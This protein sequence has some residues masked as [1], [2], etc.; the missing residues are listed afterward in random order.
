MS[1]AAQASASGAAEDELETWLCHRYYQSVYYTQLQASVLVVLNPFRAPVDVN[2]DE[3]LRQYKRALWDA[4]YTAH[5]GALPPH[6]FGTACDAYFYM[7]RTGQDQSLLF[8]GESGAGKSETRRLAVRALIG[9]SAALPGKRGARLVTQLPAAL[10]VLECFGCAATDANANASATALYAELQFSHNGRL[11]G[12]K[13]LNYYLDRTRVQPGRTQERTFHVFY[14]LLA[15]AP[16]DARQRWQLDGGFSLTSAHGRTEAAPDPAR[17]WAYERLVAALDAAGVGAA[18]RGALFDVL[19]AM[20]HVSNLTFVQDNGAFAAARVANEE[21]LYIA[22]SLLGVGASALAN[23]LTHRTA[24]V[25]GDKYTAML[26][27]DDAAAARDAFLAMLYE[28][29]Y[30]WLCQHINEHFAAA[31]FDTYIG[32]LDAPSWTN[33]ARNGVP[34]FGANYMAEALHQHTLRVLLQRRTEELEHEG[35]AHLAPPLPALRDGAERMRLLTHYPGGLLHIMDEQTRRRPP[36]TDETMVAAMQKRWV[37]SRALRVA[38]PDRPGAQ[39]FTVSHFHGEV[40]YD[41]AGALAEN[42]VSFALEHISLLRGAAAGAPADGTSGFGS[43]RAFVRGLFA[44]MPV[45]TPFRDAMPPPA[46]A[47][48]MRRP[49]R[50]GT[51]RATSTRRRGDARDRDAYDGDGPARAPASNSAVFVGGLRTNL[52]ALLDVLGETK[53]W[54]VVCVRPNGNQLANQCEPRMV[55]RQVQALQLAELRDQRARNYSVSLTYAEFCERYGALRM[56]EGLR[57]GGAPRGEAKMRVGDAC[58]QM[59]WSDTHVALGAHKVFLSHAV[60]CELEDDLRADDPAEAQYNLRRAAADADGVPD[61]YAPDA[62]GAPGPG[63]AGAYAPLAD[64]AADPYAPPHTPRDAG[65]HPAAAFTYAG[66]HDAHETQSLLGAHGADAQAAE[67]N[68]TLMDD[69]RDGGPGESADARRP[70]VAERV[71]VSRLRRQWVVV[72]WLLTFWVPSFALMWRP[73][74]RRSDVRMAWREKLAINMLIWFVCACSIF[75]IVFLGNVV[76]PNEHLIGA[77]SLSGFASGDKVYTAIRGEVFDLAGITAGH[78]ATVPVVSRKTVMSYAG[79]DATGAFPVQVNALCNG[80][81]GAISPWVSLDNSNTTDPNAQYHDFRADTVYDVRPDWYYEQM[82]YMRS[83]HRVGFIGYTPGDISDAVQDGRTMAVVDGNLYDITDYVAQGSQGGVRVPSGMAAPADLDRTILAPA[84]V[85]LITASPGRDVSAQ[86]DALALGAEVL[87]WQKACLRNLYFV[88]RVDHRDTARCTFS[89]YILLALSLVMVATIAFKFF[90]AL[91]FG[92][93]RPTEDYDKFVL[94]QVPCYTEGTDSIKKTVDSLARLKYDDR[95]KLLVV[96]CDGNVVGAGNDA[97]TPQLVLELLG[98][99]T[100]ADV[101]PRSFVS[102][103]EGAKQHNMARV[104]SGLYEHAGHMVPYLVVAKCGTSD[105]HTRP[106]N[107]GKRDTQ[108]ILMRFLNK[109]HFGLPMSPLELE[110]YHHIKNII[111]VNPSFYE[112][113][114]QVDADTEVDPHAL[115]RMVAAFVRDQKV[116]GLCGETALANEQQSITTMLQV[117]EYYISHYLVKAFESL[118][119]SITCLPG[120]FSMFRLRASDT[121]RPLFISNAVLDDYAENRVDTL[122]TKNLLYLG[123]DRYLTTLVLKHFPAHKTVFVRDAKCL[124]IA[125]DSWRV[126]LSQRRRWI[127]STVHNLVE[128]L[129]TQQLCGFCCFSMRFVVLIDLLSTIVAPVTIGYLVYLVVIVAVDGG[130]I[131]VTSIILLAAIYGLQAII[132]LLHRR[133][134][135]IGWMVVYILGLPLWSLI[136]PLYSFWHM[137]DFSWGNTRIVTGDRGEKLVLHNEGTFQPADIPHM[138]WDDYEN[139][140]WEQRAAAPPASLSERAPS[141]YGYATHPLPAYSDAD[142]VRK[143]APPDAVDAPWFATEPLYKGMGMPPYCDDPSRASMHHPLQPTYSRPDSLYKEPI[144]E[145]TPSPPASLQRD[146]L[147]PSEAAPP[148]VDL[149]RRLPHDEVIRRDIRELIAASDLSTVTKRQ[150]RLQLQDL[151]GCAIDEKKAYI[152]AQIDAALGEM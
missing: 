133:F 135:M 2:S 22:A 92:R 85:N 114:F 121:Q 86:L 113:L 77:Q 71:H 63:A 14:L 49:A 65:P 64:A 117:Y 152:N 16:P 102:L 15:G 51:L 1:D 27:A 33:R 112:Y 10:H 26:D 118:F 52:D 109:T 143:D 120:C 90:A 31:H 88:G 11:L 45:W 43:S 124:T 13:A 18:E 68:A 24:A 41:A 17:L 21:P 132:F 108:L 97:P 4:R 138:S 60:F 151:Y 111:G 148:L 61:L 3:V 12:M 46:H 7:Q 144:H 93:S 9:L 149:R 62:D 36:K 23:A 8:L 78:V 39:P 20:L 103:G 42:D 119:G 91:Q 98:A 125:P 29:V 136:L 104:Y 30:A 54:F 101:A 79:Q 122:H 126:L 95:R 55:R 69:T 34:A 76:C 134:D 66:E 25:R 84:I 58:V 80:V 129:R 116:I 105:E 40:T 47:P 87:A 141:L 32:L 115:S 5:H 44:A 83:R 67:E 150:L 82:W 28:L 56:L 75:V 72:T 131:P 123:E 19:A 142:A 145:R 147:V 127:N 107:R 106:G 6:I 96:V 59:N 50:S 130:T 57:L 53:A 35:L 146:P 48:S 74:L 94:C 37:N 89:K 99:D 100:H 140:L 110:M 73:R 139:Q 70:R 38:P 81:R 137:D 128:L